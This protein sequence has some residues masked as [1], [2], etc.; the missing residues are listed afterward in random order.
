MMTVKGSERLSMDG[1]YAASRDD[2]SRRHWASSP[3]MMSKHRQMAGFAG[4]GGGYFALRRSRATGV[5]R[6]AARAVGSGTKTPV[7]TETPENWEAAAALVV[8]S[9]K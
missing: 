4:G 3:L 5:R 9:P 2:D 7:V 6:R 1:L 8:L